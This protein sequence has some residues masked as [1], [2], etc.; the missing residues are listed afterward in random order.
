MSPLAAPLPHADACGAAGKP[1]N[2]D[3]AMLA[4]P[5]AA[6]AAEAAW[7]CRPIAA[8][9]QAPCDAPIG[10][11]AALG[12]PASKYA[13]APQVPDPAI[14]CGCAAPNSSLGTIVLANAGATEP[15]GDPEVSALERDVGKGVGPCGPS[16]SCGP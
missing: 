15:P 8:L 5:T 14:G 2:I 3:P 1:S 16:Q 6:A 12:P 10:T 11:P 7:Y 9:R 13:T 4:G